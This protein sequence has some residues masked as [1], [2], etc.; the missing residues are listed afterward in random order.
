MYATA[1]SPALRAGKTFLVNKYY[2]DHLYTD[3]IIG[4]IKGPI[5]SAAYWVNQNVIDNVLRYSGKGA[6]VSAHFVYD[7]IDQRGVDGFYNGTALITGEAGGES[8][9]LQT[10]RLQEYAWVIVGSVGVFVLALAIFKS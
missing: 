3:V 8:R 6:V 9:K 10:G 5:A 1:K 2:L 4:G 7:Y